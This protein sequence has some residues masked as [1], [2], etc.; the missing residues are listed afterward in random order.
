MAKLLSWGVAVTRKYTDFVALH[1]R[2]TGDEGLPAQILPRLPGKLLLLPRMDE[3]ADTDD[4]HALRRRQGEL[5]IYLRALLR[6]PQLSYSLALKQF[7][8]DGPLPDADAIVASAFAP[9]PAQAAAGQASPLEAS[10]TSSPLVLSAG[11]PSGG[12]DAVAIMATIVRT[13]HRLRH[14]LPPPTAEMLALPSV[15]HWVRFRAEQNFV[16]R[17]LAELER[18]EA[19]ATVRQVDCAQRAKARQARLRRWTDTEEGRCAARLAAISRR[20]PPL[21]EAVAIA[22]ER[23]RLQSGTRRLLWLSGY[24]QA[25]GTLDDQ[26]ER[27]EETRSFESLR[28][29]AS[30]W[31]D[32][33]RLEDTVR[34]EEEEE[35]AVDARPSDAA[36]DVSDWMLRHLSWNQSWRHHEQEP[37]VVDESG[38]E[39]TRNGSPPSSQQAADARE[40]PPPRPSSFLRSGP[41][42]Q[43]ARSAGA[44]S[45]GRAAGARSGA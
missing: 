11:V 31:M 37:E 26:R 18:R 44:T 7:L 19:R 36:E 22:K 5:D 33:V 39:K 24:G 42:R 10:A 6:L 32:A 43:G 28:S 4:T 21:R 29:L 41:S 25:M 14:P 15:E 8:S 16:G 45:E 34:L 38:G 9:R 40:A 23:L 30:I 1:R 3:D 20:L 27:A 35:G 2:L 17:A 13:I 12:G